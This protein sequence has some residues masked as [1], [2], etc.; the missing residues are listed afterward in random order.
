MGPLLWRE[1][2][3]RVSISTEKMMLNA[4]TPRIDRP[5]VR[6]V[7]SALTAASLLVVAACGG[8]D[9]PP[10]GNNNPDAPVVAPTPDGPPAQAGPSVKLST[11]ATLGKYLT[12]GD[13]KALYYFAKDLPA[14]GTTAAVSNCNGQC[15][16]AWPAFKMSSA[17]L[18]DGLSATDFGTLTRGDGST[19]TTYKGWPLYHY[20]ADAAAGDTT[21]D[22]TGHV[23]F[24]LKD[25]FYATLVM[26][27]ATGPAHYLADPAG[28][29]LYQFSK[30]TTGN[31]GTPPV[32]ACTGGCAS[33]WPIFA[34]TG[35]ALPTSVDPSLAT[36]QRAD[37]TP[38]ASWKG[39]PLYYFGGD[40][41]P[42]DTKG[43]G[44]GGYWSVVDP[45]AP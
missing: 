39:H 4:T 13:G 23:W 8:M 17:T 27:S 14:T 9:N 18:G 31:G 29:T 3:T 2:A 24:V 21:G 15:A 11:S 36:F 35:T 40:K 22:D 37:N 12:D 45:T 1:T 26:S 44:V 32:S 30:D 25:P 28:R 7:L 19:Q 41:I 20:A 10:A 38:Q 16:G 34:T 42:G 43:D 5:M 6:T 33:S